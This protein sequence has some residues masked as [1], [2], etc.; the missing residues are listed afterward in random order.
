MRTNSTIK[1]GRSSVDEALSSIPWLE[2][3]E[4]LRVESRVVPTSRPYQ[5]WMCENTHLHAYVEAVVCLKGS[6]FYGING[7]T[8]SFDPGSVYLIPANQ[9]HDGWYGPHH[10]ACIDFWLHL[11]PNGHV[12]MNTVHHKP[13]EGPILTPVTCPDPGLLPDLTRACL[14]VNEAVKDASATKKTICFLLFLLHSLLKNS[15]KT[16]RVRFRR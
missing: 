13:D 1:N 9:P 7:R 6:H 8:I 14:L 12:T 3:A 11:L 10:R 16:L 5:L 2:I 15:R 4:S